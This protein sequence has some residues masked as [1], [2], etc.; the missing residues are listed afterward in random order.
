MPDDLTLEEAAAASVETPLPKI[1]QTYVIRATVR[2]P[3]D[4]VKAPV[5][6]RVERVVSMALED[7]CEGDG[8]EGVVVNVTAERV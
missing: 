4:N 2:H 3:S 5:L 7:L 1:L 8:L 6:S